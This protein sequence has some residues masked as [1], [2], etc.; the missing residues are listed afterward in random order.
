MTADE[1][2]L[3]KVT[4]PLT[5][6]NPGTPEKRKYVSPRLADTIVEIIDDHDL[7]S[8]HNATV[9]VV[10]GPFAGLV[11]KIARTSLTPI[12]TESETA[13][14]KISLVAGELYRITGVAKTLEGA[15]LIYQNN[16]EVV[17]FLRIDGD[18]DAVVEA[19]SGPDDGLIQYIDP[20]SLTRYGAVEETAEVPAEDESNEYRWELDVK[21]DPEGQVDKSLVTLT[22]NNMPLDKMDMILVELGKR[23]TRIKLGAIIALKL[24]EQKED[25]DDE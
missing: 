7:T 9:K 11:Q 17:R 22:L 5:Y 10:E 15:G 12:T 20:R 24:A 19:V 21:L 13:D 1:L 25:E 18:G 14:E 23:E 4:G 3:Y 8:E 6:V 16:N 2:Y